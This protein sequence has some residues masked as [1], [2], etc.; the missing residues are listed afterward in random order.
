MAT[1]PANHYCSIGDMHDILSRDGVALSKDDYPP[2]DYGRA[3]D[4]AGNQIEKF[5]YKRYDPDQL[6]LSDLVRDWAAVIACYHL[7]TRRGNPVPPGLA[8][9]YEETIAD[10]EEIKKAQNDIPHIAPR[11]AA[12]PG[13]SVKKPTLR[14]YPRT[15][16][17][18]SQGTK[19]GGIPAGPDQH[20]DPYDRFGWNAVLD[21]Q[22]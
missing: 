5:L 11:C 21:W 7:R 2:S 6:A 9:L 17:E 18:T 15:V 20:R 16:V 22:I 13:L 12:A 14:P 8:A 10:L 4:K 19:T 1:I 3:L